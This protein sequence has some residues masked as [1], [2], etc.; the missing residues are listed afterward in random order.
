MKNTEKVSADEEKK[1]GEQS[2]DK[3]EKKRKNVGVEKKL[4]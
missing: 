1:T 4:R 3:N 2:I